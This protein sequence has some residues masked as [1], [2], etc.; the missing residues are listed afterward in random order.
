MN[1]GTDSRIGLG[2]R[3]GEHADFQTIVELGPQKETQP[4]GN[5][6]SKRRRQIV[7]DQVTE[8]NSRFRNKSTINSGKIIH[9]QAEFKKIDKEKVVINTNF[10]V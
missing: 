1:L 9:K 8:K 5:S 3:L 2:F 4:I 10:Y 7:V 6:E